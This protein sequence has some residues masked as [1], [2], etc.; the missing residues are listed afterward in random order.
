MKRFSRRR[1]YDDINPKPFGEISDI[2]ELQLGYA[3]IPLVNKE[4]ELRISSY[5]KTKDRPLLAEVTS[6][7]NYFS[8]VY[9]IHLPAVHIRDNMCLGPDEYAIYMN[10]I[11]YGKGHVYIN[12][13][14]CI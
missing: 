1:L 10:G 12:H 6:C 3:L 2:L 9:G 4:E 14:F 11:E 7:R 5:K 8:A 13:V